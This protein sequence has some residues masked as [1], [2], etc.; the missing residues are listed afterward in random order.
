VSNWFGF[1]LV[2][3]HAIEIRSKAGEDG[4]DITCLARFRIWKD[5][6]G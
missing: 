4:K 2:S 5:L 6:F 3:E 1:V